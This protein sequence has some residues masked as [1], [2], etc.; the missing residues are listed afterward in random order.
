MPD[1]EA[2]LAGEAAAGEL[3]LLKLK[4]LEETGDIVR[5]GGERVGL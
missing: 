2:T 3:V 1:I 4:E 5:P